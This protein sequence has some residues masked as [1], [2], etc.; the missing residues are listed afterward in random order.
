M[1]RL[2]IENEELYTLS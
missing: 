1:L 2:L